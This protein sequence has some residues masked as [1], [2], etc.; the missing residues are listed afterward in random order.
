M[1]HRFEVK[2]FY[3]DTDMGGIVYYANYRNFI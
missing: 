2:V 1:T 3:E